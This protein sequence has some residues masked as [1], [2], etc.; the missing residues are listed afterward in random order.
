MNSPVQL[1]SQIHVPPDTG[2]RA[3]RLPSWTHHKG[4]APGGSSTPASPEPDRSLSANRRSCEHGG[5]ILPKVS[6]AQQGHLP[7]AA[8][9]PSPTEHP[10]SSLICKEKLKMPEVRNSSDKWNG[11]SVESERGSWREAPNKQK[12]FLK[13]TRQ[14][15]LLASWV[16][17][18]SERDP[19]GRL[20]PP[21]PIPIQPKQS[22]SGV[23]L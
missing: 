2:I 12:Q 9:T 15:L 14:G 20:Q 10:V 5:P 22:G 23:Q 19:E 1:S 13:H 18:S 4:N 8:E 7:G 6:T 21:H 16:C 17:G 3:R 11:R